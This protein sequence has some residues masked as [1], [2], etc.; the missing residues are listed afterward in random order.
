MLRFLRRHYRKGMHVAWLLYPFV[1]LFAIAP[2]LGLFET[3][4]APLL[5]AGSTAPLLPDA[6]ISLPNV[7]GRI[8]HLAVDVARSH[9]FIAELGN[10]SVDVVDLATG[11]VR[12]RIG[13]LS[14]PQ[15]LG[16]APGPDLLVVASAGDG[17]VKFFS[18]TDFAPR[19]SLSL[20]EDADNVR[21]DRQTGEVV[22]GYGG[23][24]LAIIDPAKQ[25][26]LA[27]IALPAHPEGFQLAADRAFVNVPDARQIAVVDRGQRK[28]IATWR[29][30][31]AGNFPLALDLAGAAVAVV[32]RNSST[33]AL[34]DA[35][36]GRLTAQ[37]KTCGD[38]D[39][40]FIDA[41]RSRLYV[42]C[43][44][45]A[46]EVFGQQDLKRLGGVATSAGA[47][48]SL[49]VPEL[50]RLY[51]AERAGLLGANAAIQ[52]YRPN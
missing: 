25:L 15:G 44:A 9:L 11:K 42:S 39:D 52:I 12:H 6:R 45:G 43:G 47:R 1:L 49:F 23:G 41:K 50:D 35:K 19:G 37:A 10:N 3:P 2:T 17:T 34:L 30:P 51:V 28:V 48:T 20:G 7:T 27:D 29:V 5:F 4:A 40:A 16:Y 31:L 14:A 26:K 46:V 22:V 38:V 21:V 33:L 18:G 36:T 8:D 24:G 13:G 32:F